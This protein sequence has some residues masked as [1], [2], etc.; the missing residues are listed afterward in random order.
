MDDSGHVVGLYGT[1]AQSNPFS[2][3]G[4][5]LWDGS[6]ATDLGSLGGGSTTAFCIRPDSA[7][8]GTSLDSYG[9]L[10]LFGVFP[11]AIGRLTD[12]GGV[13]LYSGDTSFAP[14]SF[15]G[16][17][18]WNADS[19]EVG[20]SP[21]LDL[22]GFG[23]S[24]AG[25]TLS[26]LWKDG[27]VHNVIDLLPAYLAFRTISEAYGSKVLVNSSQQ[28]ACAGTDAS[29]Q[30]L[31]LLLSIDPDE[32]NDGLP[33][34]WEM[35]YFNHLGV[36]PNVDDDGDGKTNLQEFQ[37]GK[38]PLDYYDGNVPTLELL[39]GG[40][41]RGSPGEVLP[42]PVSV[43]V[44]GIQGDG[45]GDSNAPVVFTVSGG[46]RLAA[47]ATLP[48]GVAPT[49]ILQMHTASRSFGERQQN[50]AQVYLYLPV[51][52]ND[53][54]LLTVSVATEG[55][56]TSLTTMVVTT[57]PAIA[58]P[59]DFTA[60]PTSPT[61]AQLT[62]SSGDPSRATAVQATT[63]NGATWRTIGIVAA[64]VQAAIVSDLV[65]QATIA[66]RVFT[67]PGSTGISSGSGT[68]NQS[69]LLSALS[70]VALPATGGNG[71]ALTA[72]VFIKP[73]RGTH[74]MA[75]IAAGSPTTMPGFQGFINGAPPATHYLTRTL[76]ETGIV[77]SQTP[78]NVVFNETVNLSGLVSNQF[79][80]QSSGPDAFTFD[81]Q[82]KA[83]Y[84]YSNYHRAWDPPA[85]HTTSI[86]TDTYTW[87][88]WAS[89]HPFS[90]MGDTKSEVR[91]S[92]PFSSSDWE[93]M[94]KASAVFRNQFVDFEAGYG[95]FADRI[96]GVSKYAPGS[97][98]GNQAFV[99]SLHR[100]QYQWRCNSEPN[101]VVRWDEVF[102][103]YDEELQGLDQS[104]SEHNL[105]QWVTSGAI[106]SQVYVV[107][108][109]QRR[110]GQHGRYEI[111]PL[112]DTVTSRDRFV[113]GT[114]DPSQMSRVDRVQFINVTTKE[115]LGTYS[116]STDPSTYVYPSK[117]D[118]FSD[119][120]LNAVLQNQMPANSLSMTQKV[121]LYKDKDYP[122]KVHFSAVFGQ[123]GS[124]EIRF[125]D[126]NGQPAGKLACTLTHD[127]SFGDLINTLAKRLAS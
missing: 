46:A 113:T 70:S 79:T 18:S 121:L 10:H 38:N 102:T 101:K 27:V 30:Q 98:Y 24:A 53:S 50:V 127:E 26:L 110:N 33:D 69:A 41:Q 21:F 59:G 43:K 31:A 84:Y 65:P 72:S 74:L 107:D 3:V 93:T 49:A 88:P 5:F 125:L 45:A 25:D 90:S 8:L 100:L 124:V 108:P 103:P 7:I 123:V 67:A 95:A 44:F 6:T 2:T 115:D 39:G 122:T 60:V 82:A 4:S 92:N 28:I 68:T 36:D 55:V 77:Y 73:L 91:L 40:D 51:Q 80:W 86:D 111:V 126:F 83:Y 97:P 105:Q 34:S 118:I 23:T 112:N 1:G 61:T 37:T 22:A 94:V 42:V 15:S 20:V 64:G 96:F 11:E 85:T 16:S 116:F 54:S 99:C 19:F 48:S 109:L 12:L 32:D 13:G 106:Q 9:A 29:G 35:Q 71:S 76:D 119:A 52:A 104:K 81:T 57:D 14:I 89:D 117:D 114:F 62:W 63:D 56:T 47:T 120:E 17:F 75:E 78:S 87:V 58:P 66:F